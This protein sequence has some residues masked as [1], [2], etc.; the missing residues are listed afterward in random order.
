MWCSVETVKY[1]SIYIHT[2]KYILWSLIL[3]FSSFYMFLHNFNPF[4]CLSQTIVTPCRHFSA[5][6]HYYIDRDTDRAIVN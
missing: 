1:N 6:Q 2:Y 5:T 3:Y 4:Y